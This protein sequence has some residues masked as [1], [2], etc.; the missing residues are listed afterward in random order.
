MVDLALAVE[1]PGDYDNDT[2]AVF[3]WVSGEIERGDEKLGND[4][5]GAKPQAISTRNRKRWE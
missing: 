3:L 5:L 1:L 2:V 4:A